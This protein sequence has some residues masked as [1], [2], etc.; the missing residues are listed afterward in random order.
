MATI[1]RA[2]PELRDLIERDEPLAALQGALSEVRTGQGR[3]VLVA[4]E[5]GVGKTSLVRAFCGRALGPGRV[6]QGACEPLA[7]PRP[8]APFSGIAPEAAGSHEAWDAVCQ[9]L[10]RSGGSLV[11]E[12]L[13]WADEASLDVVRMIG[14]RV[15]LVPALI[16]VTYRDDELERTHP[17]RVMLG[18]LAGCPGVSRVRVEPLS[19]AGVARLAAGHALDPAGL[20]RLTSGNPFYV[21]EV[22]EAGTDEIPATVADAV[23]ARMARV[24]EPA[25][26][27]LAA[28]A[29]AP[30]H[31]EPWL[32]ERVCGESLNA[33][34]ECFAVGMLV[35]DGAGIAYRHELARM[36]VEQGLPPTHRRA[37]H[38]TMLEALEDA[39]GGPDLARLAHHAEGAGDAEAVLRLAPAAG[40]RAAALGAHREAAAQYARALRF[41]QDLSPAERAD[42]LEMEAEALYLTDDQAESIVALREA[43][44]CHQETGDVVRE[45]A[46]LSRVVSRLACRGLLDEASES[47]ERAIELLEPD[48]PSRERAAAHSSVALVALY[49]DDFGAATSHGTRA[50]ELARAAGDQ[51]VLL[52]ALTYAGSA[53]L[54]IDGPAGAELLQ[55]ALDVAR[56]NGAAVE[57]TNVLH[58]LAA[59]ATVHRDHESAERYIDDALEHCLEAD[60]DLWRL[61]VLSIK[62]RLDLNRGRWTSATDIAD[63]LVDDPRDS[64][65]PMFEGR[66]VLALVRARRGDPGVHQV[67][68]E[69]VEMDGPEEELDWFGSLALAQAEIAWLEGRLEEVG[70]LTGRA[71]EVARDRRV[72]WTLGE[73]ACWRRRAGIDDG[74][75]DGVPEPYGL[76]LAGRYEEAS[77]AWRDL[78]CPY[79]SALVFGL[80]DD[81]DS[82]RR[83]HAELREMGAGPAASQVARRLRERGVLGVARGPRRRTQENPA[84][85]TPRELDVLGLVAQGMANSEIADRLFLSPRTVDHHVSSILRKLDVPSRARASVEAARLG[86]PLD[87]G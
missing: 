7:T 24:S 36:T 53:Q 52:Q 50:V 86:I 51:H 56:A 83:S 44:A 33:V 73:L 72:P 84:N 25:M 61:A 29:I 47:A 67:L 23:R 43:I 81:P 37:L 4:G 58:N 42:L 10:E 77:A 30:P 64:P 2:S 79:E 9:E 66:L 34:G 68:S 35:E 74:A 65:G 87:G 46:A 31:L 1:D 22:L 16:V 5:A 54:S 3:L 18:D 69:A 26:S 82:L 8:L 45:G 32:L 15:G 76:E 19:P 49:V 48:G 6:L 20:F 38:R 11:V 70:E 39:P 40:E 78:G 62:A 59:G 71:F 57:A 13:H 17:L 55:E 41:A 28:A 85:L 80:S 63:V 12:D 27:V 21:T 14:R 75:V 60:L